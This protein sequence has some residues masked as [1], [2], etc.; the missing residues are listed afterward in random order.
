MTFR[1]Y[2]KGI[3]YV[4]ENHQPQ[5]FDTPTAPPEPPS[6]TWLQLRWGRWVPAIVGL[7]A[8]FV[9]GLMFS[10]FV[11]VL[12]KIFQPIFI[13]L[14]I[15]VALA[16]IIKP[17][18]D[19]FERRGFGWI[20]NPE[21]R[22]QTSVLVAMVTSIGVLLLVLFIFV[23]S[24]VTQLTQAVQKIP[25]A[26]Q[27]VSDMTK[28]MLA[29][30]Q[31][32]YPAQYEQVASNLKGHFQ[33]T[34]SITDPLMKG[35]GATFTNLIGVMTS[36]L[37]LLLIPFFIY[38]I[39]KDAR[40]LRRKVIELMPPRYQKTSDRIVNMIDSALSNFVRGQ[41]LVCLCMAFLYTICFWI[42]GVPSA[43][44]LGFL[45]GFGHLVP[46]VGTAA[47]GLLTGA[48]TIADDQSILH[49]VLVLAVYPVVQTTEGFVLTPFILG[50]R[51][52]LHPFLVIVG[53][54]V[55][56]HLFGI[57]G[58]IL[59]VPVLAT[60]KVLLEVI[61]EAYVESGF[62]TYLAPPKPAEAGASPPPEVAPAPAEIT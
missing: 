36:F 29:K 28:P 52:D 47:A 39:L 61:T 54:L 25:A 7:L 34:S 49:L 50:E 3:P 20:R 9:F 10:G 21:L 24:L 35:V 62:Y 2:P 59:A 48:L 40:A 58:I 44:P 51:L 13:P 17:L 18:A 30:L 41:L 60:S 12:S 27:K 53:L 32:K 16:Y 4:S 5:I 46:Y 37:N 42:L 22:Q 31:E 1:R 6:A 14:L 19:W 33:E 56:H 55:G 57:L 43:L 26:Y 45:S 23:P 11:S 8:V 38:Y 15:S